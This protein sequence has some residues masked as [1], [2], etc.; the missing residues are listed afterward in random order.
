[1]TEAII[2]CVLGGAV[3]IGLAV[4]SL[5]SFRAIQSFLPGFSVAPD[6]VWLG[7]GI[8]VLLGAITGIVPAL[9]ASRLSVVEALRRV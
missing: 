1:M 3:G 6:T 4:L 7:F 9:Q 2:I 8:A 5:S